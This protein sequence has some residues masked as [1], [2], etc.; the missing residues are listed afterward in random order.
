[1]RLPRRFAPR[2]D[3]FIKP[4]TIPMAQSYNPSHIQIGSITENQLV[5]ALSKQFNIP[6][7]NGERVEDE[8]LIV[9]LSDKLDHQFLI[10]NNFLPLKIDHDD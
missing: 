10:K 3:Y 1:M 8:G 2:N 9:Y 7:F 5:E 6:L 4:F